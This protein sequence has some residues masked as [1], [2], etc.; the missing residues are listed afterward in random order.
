MVT[1]LTPGLVLLFGSEMDR[2]D[3][4]PALE[5]ILVGVEAL[6]SLTLSA[7]LDLIDLLAALSERLYDIIHRTLEVSMNL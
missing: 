1:Y 3:F 4:L 2:G 7:F 6:E 5:G